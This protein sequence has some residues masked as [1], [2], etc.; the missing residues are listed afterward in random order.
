MGTNCDENAAAPVAAKNNS[1]MTETTVNV[2]GQEQLSS[3]SFQRIILPVN[4][5]TTCLQFRIGK[6]H[7]SSQNVLRAGF[8]V[9]KNDL[10]YQLEGPT[11]P[12]IVTGKQHNKAYVDV[13]HCTVNTFIHKHPNHLI[14]PFLHGR[15]LLEALPSREISKEQ[16]L[17]SLKT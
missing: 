3:S 13:V 17:G 16:Y 15:I 12:R 2:W 6:T 1:R 14:V 9:K 7:S 11:T 10:L 5:I 4:T 8:P